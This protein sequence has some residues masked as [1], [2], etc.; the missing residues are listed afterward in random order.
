M[1]TFIAHIGKKKI[2]VPTLRFKGFEGEW[3]NKKLGDFASLYKGKGISKDDIVDNGL[4][5]CIRYGELYTTY[6]E[7]IKNVVSKTNLPPLDLFL[8]EYNDVIIPASGETQIDIATA[9]CV[10]KSGVA[11]SGDL[12]VIRSS[13]NG[14]FLSFYLNSK[15]K[16]DIARLSQ[17]SSVMHLY[18]SQLKLLKL[19][20]PTLPEQQK[21][22]SFLSAV[23]EKIQQLSRKKELLEQYKKGV[24][25]QLFSGTLRFKDE[26]GKAFPKWEEKRL[27]DVGEI[28][29]GKTPSTTDL[30]LWNGD[31]QFVTPTDINNNKYQLSTQRTIKELAS[32]RI[33]PAKSIMFTCIASIG[34]MSMS[35]KPCITNQQINSVVPSNKFDN[36][37]IYYSLLNLS[38][39][40]KS[41]QSTTTLP[42]IN[43]TEFSKFKINVPIE[44][45]EQQKIATYLSNIDI[46]IESVNKQIVQSQSFKKG[47]LQGMFV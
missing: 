33:L 7:I 23:D 45:K 5:E 22:A 8:S 17:G 34:K 13:M 31:I 35:I 1:S 46:K 4:L 36:E 15:K 21:I 30:N 40:I 18:S 20:I 10:L 32:T 14:V 39:F 44:I 28:V 19:T 41:T 27:G 43:K 11:L 3:I 12:N 37:F 25:Q 9:S 42:I 47:L 29:T 16:F 6:N 38:D 26:K 2:L 24:M